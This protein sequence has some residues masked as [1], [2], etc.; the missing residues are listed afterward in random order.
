V[1]LRRRQLQPQF[2]ILAFQAL[3]QL[4]E[5]VNFAIKRVEFRIHRHTIVSKN[6][7]SQVITGNSQCSFHDEQTILFVERARDFEAGAA[8]PHGTRMRV[9]S[10]LACAC[11]RGVAAAILFAGD[12]V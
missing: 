11:A 9:R 8:L 12:T 4:E 7:I 6:V 2:F 1:V 10:S 5:L 3:A